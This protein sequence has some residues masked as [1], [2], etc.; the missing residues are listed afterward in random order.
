MTAHYSPDGA[1]IVTASLGKGGTVW[2]ASNGKRIFDFKGEDG[3]ALLSAQYSPDGKTILAIGVFGGAQVWSAETGAKL[4]DLELP[5]EAILK[6][7][8]SPDGQFI[9]TATNST[10]RLWK[11]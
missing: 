2:D 10:V 3:S 5:N 11:R 9:I 6:A 1:R 4:Q 8:F 7:E